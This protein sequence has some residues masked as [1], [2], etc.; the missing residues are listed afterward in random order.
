MRKPQE[1]E[2]AT[3]QERKVNWAF[4][5][6]DKNAKNNKEARKNC[7]ERIAIECLVEKVKKGEIPP[8]ESHAVW[9]KI[10]AYKEAY[11]KSIVLA[12]VNLGTH[13]LV[14]SLRDLYIVY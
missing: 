8:E 9:E 10:Y 6:R 7:K 13:I 11:R 14:E 5:E 2:Q 12:A 3:I 1:G 4:Y